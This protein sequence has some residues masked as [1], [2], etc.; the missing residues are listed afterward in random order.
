MKNIEVQSKEN[1]SSANLIRRFSR[2][3]RNSGILNKARAN[4]EYEREKSENM[5][6]ESALEQKRRMEQIE[7]LIK[8]GKLPDRRNRRQVIQLETDDEESS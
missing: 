7:T 1:E 4:Q 3:V 5:K 8:L 6:K 2:R